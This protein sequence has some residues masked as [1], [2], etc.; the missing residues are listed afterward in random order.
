[1][2]QEVNWV[3]FYSFQLVPCKYGDER[4]RNHA[5]TIYNWPSVYHF[6]SVLRMVRWKD[7]KAI[8]IK[9]ST[10]LTENDHG[11]LEATELTSSEE[12][13]KTILEHFPGR[14][15]P[16]EIE[17]ALR[18]VELAQIK[19]AIKHFLL[20]QF[21]ALCCSHTDISTTLMNQRMSHI[22][23]HTYHIFLFYSYGFH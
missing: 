9:G 21:V 17:D 18:H 16:D 14:Y 12:I 15:L 20:T 1:M 5:A 19:K 10:L 3:P 7:G 6:H 11:K 8:G 23:N 4:V 2:S 22:I 13:K